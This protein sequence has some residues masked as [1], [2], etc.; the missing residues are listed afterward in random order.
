MKRK[1]I[2]RIFD[3]IGSTL[4]SL[5]IL[6]FIAAHIFGIN[7][8]IISD[9]TIVQFVLLLV[10]G[11]IVLKGITKIVS[12]F[13]NQD[14]SEQDEWNRWSSS[15]QYKDEKKDFSFYSSTPPPPPPPPNGS[16]SDYNAYTEK[17]SNQSKL[18]QKEYFD[19]L[20]EQYQ[21]SKQFFKDQKEYFKEH[22]EEFK[23][24]KEYYKKQKDYDK[25]Q[26]NYK[27][28][29]AYYSG[30]DAHTHTDWFG[31]KKHSYDKKYSDTIYQSTFIGDFKFKDSYWQLKPMELSAFIGDAHID[32]TRAEIPVGETHISMSAFIGDMKIHVPNDPRIGVKVNLSAFIG[33]SKLF[34]D[35]RGGFGVGTS[36]ETPFYHECERK[37]VVELNSFIGDVKVKRVG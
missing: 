10:G 9:L 37:I 18:N 7:I 36:M 26:D 1:R 2:K 3:S 23:D 27:D 20:K 14:S 28:Q 21:K 34:S 31:T 12:A 17:D 5:L 29:D 19:E 32:L 30:N 8:W 22:K 15:I 4:S 13:D 11:N 16:F 25:D 33:E 24:Q 35:K 6:A